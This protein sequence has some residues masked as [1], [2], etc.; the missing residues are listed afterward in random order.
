MIQLPR[1]VLAGVFLFAAPMLAQDVTGTVQGM[2]TDQ[3]GARISSVRVEL[4]N[5]G[6]KVT[7]VRTANAEGE[8]LFNLVPP[9]HYTVSASLTGFKSA[10]ITGIEVAVN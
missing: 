8:Y 3:T 9:G 2:V 1:R 4:I 5:E 7:S 10:N 6:T